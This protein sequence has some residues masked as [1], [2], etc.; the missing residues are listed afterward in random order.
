MIVDV[1]FDT[2]EGPGLMKL[3]PLSSATLTALLFFNCVTT[4]EAELGV[5]GPAAER[6]SCCT[7]AEAS[8]LR[9]QIHR[10]QHDHGEQKKGNA[11]VLLS[12]MTAAA[13]TH[14]NSC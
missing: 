1:K 8:A 5:T 11:V 2:Q 7:S 13:R 4:G 10:I 6:K 9:T 14:W 3:T 12:S